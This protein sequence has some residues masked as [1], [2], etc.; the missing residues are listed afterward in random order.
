M[1]APSPT[2]ASD[3]ELL[4]QF[5]AGRDVKCAACGYNLRDLTATKC[6]ECGS[7]LSLGM[8]PCEKRPRAWTF[9]VVGSAITTGLALAASGDF[10]GWYFESVHGGFLPPYWFPQH[11]LVGGIACAALLISL[12]VWPHS[13]YRLAR[14]IRVFIAALPWAL[15]LAL[16]FFSL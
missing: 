12:L 6:P 11:L 10:A 4:R 16:L 2:P 3:A 8:G 5:L 15:C 7:M 14:S 1:S 9:A 13:L